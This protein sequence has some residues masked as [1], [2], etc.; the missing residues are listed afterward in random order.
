MQLMIDTDTATPKALVLTAAYLTSIANIMDPDAQIPSDPPRPAPVPVNDPRVMFG[1]NPPPVPPGT[2]ITPPPSPPA[3][4]ASIVT[5]PAIS[6][7]SPTS[8]PAGAYVA[9]PPNVDAKGVAHD[10]A[11]HSEKPTLNADG[12][13]RARRGLAKNPTAATTD[14]P[15]LPVETV[16]ASPVSVVPPPPVQL[17]IVPP[18]PA[19]GGPPAVLPGAVPNNVTTFGVFMQCISPLLASKQLSSATL[20]ATLATH[21]VQDVGGLVAQPMLIPLVWAD[22]RAACGV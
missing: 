19:P 3:P 20:T 8:A 16:T 2:S 1:H 18:P 6:T 7:A 22:I 12:T 10:P 13:W 4:I 11:I 17:H 5:A 15:A 9:P 14:T 21:G